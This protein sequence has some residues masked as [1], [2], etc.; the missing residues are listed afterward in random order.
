MRQGL[1]TAAAAVCVGVVALAACS[2][3]GPG[4]KGPMGAAGG[5]GVS[6]E[7]TIENPEKKGPDEP[8]LAGKFYRSG[9]KI[10]MEFSEPG[11]KGGF[12]M[13]VDQSTALMLITDE[14]GK[15]T[16]IKAPNMA[17]L[18]K[19][20]GEDGNIFSRDFTK[21]DANAT[22]VGPCSAAGESGKLY[23]T[24]TDGRTSDVCFGDVGM[25][26]EMTENGTKVWQTTKVTRGAPDAALFVAPAGVEVL[27]MEAMFKGMGID[28][29]KMMKEMEKTK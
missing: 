27:D 21:P 13:I 2:P 11:G 17:S 24:T 12:A 4:A 9:D 16:G 20:Q 5:Q 14:A 23:R 29:E 1:F 26:L 8:R 28:P 7:F 6:A 18:A 15:V 10:R 3:G 22:L 19:A 25:P